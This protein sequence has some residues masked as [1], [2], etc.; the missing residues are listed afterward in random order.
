M[1]RHIA[2]FNLKDSA[3][4]QSKA[5]N[6]QQIIKNVER[7]RE[8]INEIKFI[9]VRPHY[10][11]EDAEDAWAWDLCVYVELET[12]QDYKTYFYNPVHKEV[13]GFAKEVSEEV[14]AITFKD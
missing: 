5:E 8:N 3:N 10:K 13:A 14:S 4:G 9:T 2:L 12:E 6:T 7:L 11:L 1:F